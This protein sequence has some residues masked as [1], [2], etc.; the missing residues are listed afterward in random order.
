MLCT[1]CK[2]KTSME[3]CTAK[4]LK[5]LQ[6]CGR[7]SKAKN[8][9]LWHKIHATDKP[10]ILIQKIWRGWMARYLL[11]LAGPGVLKR[12]LCHNEEDLVTCE[13]KTKQCPYDYFGFLEGGKVYW[14]DVRT[15]FEWSLEQLKPS[16][17]YT[18]QEL[19]L[20]TRKRL[21]EC[22]YYREVRKMPLFHDTVIH[23]SYT[24]VFQTRWM[25]ISQMLEEHLFLDFNPLYFVGLNRQQLWAF[26]HHL[27]DQ[28]LVWAR[29]HN[30]LYS[31]RNVYYV[32][33]TA[34]LRRQTFEINTQMDTAKYLG[35]TLL[36]ILKDCKNPYD[37]CFKILSAR[38]CL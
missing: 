37:I 26:T 25:L 5:N 15:I 14:F 11:K 30:G 34:C 18:K 31:R 35:G 7:H 3:Q 36:K 16:N 20:E 33:I 29:E 32:W 27:R 10:A 23:A 17:P 21:K 6:F 13:E 24:K 12:S 8:P 1:S 4:A 28:L 9:R 2:N 19:D 38:H 22:C